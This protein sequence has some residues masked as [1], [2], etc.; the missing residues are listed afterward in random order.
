VVPD[1]PTR[2]VRS[3]KPSISRSLRLFTAWPD[4]PTGVGSCVPTSWFARPRSL[5]GV[6][7]TGSICVFRSVPSPG[8]TVGRRIP[9]RRF[10]SLAPV[11]EPSRCLPRRRG[12]E[13][14][15]CR[16]VPT[17]ACR[18]RGIWQSGSGVVR[19][20]SARGTLDDVRGAPIRS[21]RG[22]SGHTLSQAGADDGE[23]PPTADGPW[24]RRDR[25]ASEY[26]CGR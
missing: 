7:T 6:L 5:V 20:A 8:S 2:T 21:R 19:R 9:V 4:F 14:R 13:A 26:W 17:G 12:T 3:L 25:D 18:L 16:H 15:E 1:P 11:A 24:R 10:R 23:M 22:V